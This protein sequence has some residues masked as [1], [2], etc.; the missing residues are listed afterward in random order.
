MKNQ[1][2]STLFV[3]LVALSVVS[4]LVSNIGAFKQNAFFDWSVPGGTI[5]FVVTYILSDVF[6]EVYGYKAS[7]F[8]SWLGFALNMFAVLMLQVAIWMPA[9]EWF[10]YSAEFELVLG[11]TP[12]ILIAGMAAYIC[13]DWLND[14]VFHK[15]R[16]RHGKGRKFALRAIVSSFCGEVADSTIFTLAAF[17]GVLPWAEIPGTIATL[18]ILKTAYEIIILPVTVVIVEKV[19]KYEHRLE[20]H[21]G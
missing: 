8:S 20:V 2:H 16:Q 11:Q 15:M 10:E 14:V 1:K 9:P 19:R 6:S 18:V 13:G 12:R 5:V 7:R 17:A 4:M 3:I 21:N